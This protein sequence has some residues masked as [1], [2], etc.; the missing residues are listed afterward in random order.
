MFNQ[1]YQYNHSE[2][3]DYPIDYNIFPLAKKCKFIKVELNANQYLHI[4]AHWNHWVYTEPNTVAISFDIMDIQGEHDYNSETQHKIIQRIPYKKNGN[5]FKFNY[6]KFIN[7]SV[8][9]TFSVIYSN[10]DDTAPVYKNEHQKKYFK[11]EK[12]ET[13]INTSITEDIYAYIGQYN[14][15]ANNNYKEIMDHYDFDEDTKNKYGN[16]LFQYNFESTFKDHYNNFRL[17]FDPKIWITLDKGV[18]S[19]LHNDDKSKFLYVLCGKKTVY[20]AA[21]SYNEFI[22][23]KVQRRVPKN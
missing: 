23:L 10:T 20:L 19:G 4:P 9:Y 12:L 6:N 17:R 1:D 5:D 21:P 8:N 14:I 16:R 13:I 22:Y 7:S 2:I 15:P 18:N 3:I 11:R